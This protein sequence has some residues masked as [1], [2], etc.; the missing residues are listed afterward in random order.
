M[1]DVERNRWERAKGREL[2]GQP[3]SSRIRLSYSFPDTHK[4]HKISHFALVPELHNFS[5]Y[6]Q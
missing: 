2:R 4:V 6:S 5:A 3:V 1:F